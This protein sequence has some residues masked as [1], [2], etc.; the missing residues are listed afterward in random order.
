[1]AKDYAAL[2]AELL[3]GHPVTG[4]YSV[5]DATAA[6]E[7][8][9]LNISGEIGPE[10]ILEYFIENQHREN[11]GGDT[12]NTNLYG[13][14]VMVAESAEGGNPFSLSPADSLTVGQI[15]AAKTI[16]RMLDGDAYSVNLSNVDVD[17]AFTKCQGA[18]V[19]STAQK[20]A[21]V[22][23]SDNVQSRAQELGFGRVRAQDVTYARAL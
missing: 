15:A 11:N 21:I 10:V 7:L 19:Y 6:D 9:A 4:A 16:L 3:A 13:R 14:L 23:L 22:G 2:Q 12:Q 1:M 5:D 8:N 17:G 20:N 18:N